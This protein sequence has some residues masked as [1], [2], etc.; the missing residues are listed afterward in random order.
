[1]VTGADDEE[2]GSAPPPSTR[3]PGSW[4]LFDGGLDPRGVHTRQ[5]LV[6]RCSPLVTL[7]CNQPQDSHVH[8]VADYV[9]SKPVRSCTIAAFRLDPRCQLLVIG[10]RLSDAGVM[11]EDATS[12]WRPLTRGEAISAGWMDSDIGCGTVTRAYDEWFYV[13][14]DMRQFMSTTLRLATERNDAEWADVMRQPAW[15]GSPEPV[16]VFYDRLGG[17]TPHDYE[18]MLL[19]AVLRDAVTAY[20]VYLGK[21]FD[22]VLNRHGRKRRQSDRTPG[23]RELERS[24]ALLGLKPKTA[25]VKHIIDLRDLLTHRRGALR[26]EADRS[27]FSD[28]DEAFGGYLAH[29]TEGLVLG[30]CDVLAQN[31]RDV[32]PVMWAYGWGSYRVPALA[33]RSQPRAD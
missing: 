1:M 27:R 24:Y 25:D 7:G 10:S 12:A 33:R 31:V 9:G 32:D 26:T 30:Y 11:T 13:D 21:A 16:D 2:E 19:A 5:D 14:R 28:Q 6:R 15:D 20:E 23:W 29:L 18:W 22:E 8:R 17:L 4:R 3:P